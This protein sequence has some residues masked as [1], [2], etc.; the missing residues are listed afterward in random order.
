MA[1]VNGG[2][3]LDAEF[4]KPSLGWVSEWWY[5]KILFRGIESVVSYRCE[6]N[7]HSSFPTFRHTVVQSGG[8]ENK[9]DRKTND[10]SPQ[11]GALPLQEIMYR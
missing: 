11:G 2:K 9:H 1:R 7:K 5:H 10:P 3:L 4:P 6:H 8:Y